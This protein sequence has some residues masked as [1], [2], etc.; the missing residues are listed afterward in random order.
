MKSNEFFKHRLFPY[1]SLAILWILG[2]VYLL[3]MFCDSFTELIMHIAMGLI[4][5]FITVMILN[6]QKKLELRFNGFL[7]PKREY[8]QNGLI[9]VI[10]SAGLSGL[11]F[12]SFTI[13]WFSFSVA[14]LGIAEFILFRFKK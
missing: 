7:N 13:G 4:C 2:N 10:L 8:I 3:Y 11:T 9:I 5:L 14:V 1:F 6:Y 12:K